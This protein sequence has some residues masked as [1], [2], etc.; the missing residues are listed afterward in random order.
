LVGIE[1]LRECKKAKNFI[2]NLNQKGDPG[3]GPLCL[4]SRLILQ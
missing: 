3:V 1:G 4:S 2:T